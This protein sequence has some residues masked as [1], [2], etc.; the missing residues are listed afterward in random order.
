MSHPRVLVIGDNRGRWSWKDEQ[1]MI[2]Y[3]NGIEAWVLATE[4]N[5]CDH[6]QVTEHDVNT[7]DIVICN[8]NG[9][10]NPVYSGK[11]ISL[12]ERRKANVKW[13]SLL[14]GDMRDF[15]KPLGTIRPLFN[16]STLVNCIN[17]Y[18]TQFL[19]SLTNTPVAYVGIPYPVR[20][21][22]SLALTKSER[23]QRVFVCPFMLNRWNDYS[24]ASAL[25]LPIVGYQKTLR[26]TLR[27]LFHNYFTYGTITN[28]NV[29]I[30]RTYQLYKDDSIQIIPERNLPAY[31]NE[32]RENILWINLDERYTWG[33]YVLDA[34]AL[35]IPIIT[36]KN[37]GHGPIL[38]PQTTL[39]TPFDIPQAIELGNRLLNDEAFYE[40]V[41]S[42]ASSRIDM[43]SPER[44]TEKLYTELGVS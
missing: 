33:R 16:A 26:R 36:T 42:Y 11:Y 9:L 4:G 24:V 10:S 31:F 34:A 15:L 6:H 39:E 19:Q 8:T 41:S 27:T 23:K 7:H 28:K 35:G 21:I 17:I 22:R 30:D 3:M 5:Y 18:A 20:G 29:L 37:T 38:F 2:P 1:H 14:E 32:I 40:E 13:V 12:A 25:G 44:I 43:Y